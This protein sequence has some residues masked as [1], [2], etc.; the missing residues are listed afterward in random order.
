MNKKALLILILLGVILLT[1]C[2]FVYNPIF[3]DGD[4]VNIKMIKSVIKNLKDYIEREDIDGLMSIVYPL[5]PYYLDIENDYTTLFAQHDNIEWNYEIT[6][7]LLKGDGTALVIG[8]YIMMS[9]YE[10]ENGEIYIVMKQ[11]EMG[12]WCIYSI[13]LLIFN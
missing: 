2:E 6:E 11:S 8:G 13:D 1:G 9:S 7:I 5:S 12:L 10:K 3:D 4:K